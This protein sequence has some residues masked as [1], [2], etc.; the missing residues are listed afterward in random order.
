MSD[1]ERN[2][3]KQINVPDDTDGTHIVTEYGCRFPDGHHEW[4]TFTA[5]NNQPFAYAS[6]IVG[7]DKPFDTS[8]ANYWRRT[9]NKKAEAASIPADGFAEEHTFVKR[10]VILVTT[11]PEEV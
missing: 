3:I 8:A 7:S 5:F 1:T 4:A 11:A 2:T 9:L 6:I 10:T